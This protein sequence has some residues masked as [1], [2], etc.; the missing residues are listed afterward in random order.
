MKLKNDRK[1][2]ASA[3]GIAA[4]CGAAV[5]LAGSMPALAFETEPPFGAMAS[6]ESLSAERAA[7]FAGAPAV[8]P[9]R[10]LEELTLRPTGPAELSLPENGGEAG[11]S[12][13]AQRAELRVD[14]TALSFARAEGW[15]VPHGGGWLLEREFCADCRLAPSAVPEPDR[16]TLLAIGLVAVVFMAARNRRRRFFVPSR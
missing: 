15:R 5:I 9:Q 3:R 2:I 7:S 13:L 4:L 11:A 14:D 6:F 1:R 8:D 16:V 12:F 10:I